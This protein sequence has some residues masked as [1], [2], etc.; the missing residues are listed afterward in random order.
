MTNRRSRPEPVLADSVRERL[1]ALLDEVEPRRAAPPTVQGDDPPRAVPEPTGRAKATDV[2]RREEPPA[3]IHDPDDGEDAAVVDLAT[4]RSSRGPRRREPHQRPAWIEAA[5][6]FTRDHLVVVVIMAG[7]WLLWTGWSLLQSRTMPVA[8]AVTASP[9]PTAVTP[10]AALTI[11]VHVIGSVVCPGVVTLPQGA[12]VADALQAAGGLTLDADPGELNLAAELVDGA[13]IVVGDKVNPRGE[14]RTTSSDPGSAMGGTGAGTATQA[15]VN[16][17]TAS[18]AELDTLP[19]VGPVTAQK[20]IDW[21]AQHGRFT[22]IEE[23]QEV[24][25]I[26]PKAY[27]QL[28]DR[29]CV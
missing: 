20:I 27:A 28:A 23:L 10:S 11:Q 4:V 21:R 8:V 14:V 19:G 18:L 16:L 12:R 24:D 9:A 25:G 7:A 6:D 1:E 2:P 17:N 13:Q 5:R 22:R 29:V 15:K 3:P 26:G